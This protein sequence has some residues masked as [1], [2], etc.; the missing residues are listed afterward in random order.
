MNWKEL[1]TYIDKH[2][3]ELDVEVPREGLWKDLE[4]NLER[5]K[6]LL[7]IQSIF[8]LPSWK[9]A[10]TFLLAIGLVVLFIKLMPLDGM[11]NMAGSIHVESIYQFSEKEVQDLIHASELLKQ[12]ILRYEDSL[13][14]YALEQYSFSDEYVGDLAVKQKKSEV[15]EKIYRKNPHDEN[16]LFSLVEAYKGEIAVWK[17]FI[18]R[19]ES[20]SK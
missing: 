17:E 4:K 18:E 13:K 19:L 3:E 9:V 7:G 16:H 14:E 1:E 5:P 2:R 15:L 11:Q 6:L 20:S 10:A 8:A 12:E